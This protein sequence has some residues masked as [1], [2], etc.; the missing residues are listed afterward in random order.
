MTETLS[1]GRVLG[2]DDR[3]HWCPS[4]YQPETDRFFVV[5]SSTGSLRI[6][7]YDPK[8]GAWSLG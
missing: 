5:D 1:S 6:L 4:Y 2:G 7:I 8:T 3:H